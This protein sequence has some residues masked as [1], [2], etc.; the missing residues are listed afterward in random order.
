MKSVMAALRV[1]QA[2]D[3]ANLMDCLTAQTTPTP[4][5][6]RREL[7]QPERRGQTGN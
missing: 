5:M 7:A 3:V 1:L 2:Q 4:R 6:S